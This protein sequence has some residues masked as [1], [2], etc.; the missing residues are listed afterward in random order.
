MHE[1]PVTRS[2]LEIVERHAAAAGAARVIR[3]HLVV[4]ELTGF[5]PDSIQFYFDLL[6]RGSRAEGA[7]LLIEQ[8][9]GR[10]RCTQCDRTYKPQDGMIWTCPECGALG[11]EVVAGKDMYVK[12]IE[13]AEGVD[14]DSDRRADTE[15]Q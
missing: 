8:E 11:G 7:A 15:R 12:S 4:G 2:I 3:I 10:I 5:V 13:T 14:G 9:P 1:L 6:S